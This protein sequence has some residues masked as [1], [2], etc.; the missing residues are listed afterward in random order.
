MISL[1]ELGDLIVIAESV[2]SYNFSPVEE[3]FFGTLGFMVASGT[4]ATVVNK[5]IINDKTYVQILYDRGPTWLH[6]TTIVRHA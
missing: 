6:P 2:I 3:A 1:F 4:V 5:K